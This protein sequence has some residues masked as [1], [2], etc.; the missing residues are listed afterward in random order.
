MTALKQKALSNGAGHEKNMQISYSLEKQHT[1]LELP[2][3][4]SRPGAVIVAG[5]LGHLRAT[6]L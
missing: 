3:A 2:E 6:C 1:H 4:E 5:S